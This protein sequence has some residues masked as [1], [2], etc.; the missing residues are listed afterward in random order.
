MRYRKLANTDVTLSEVGFGVW[1]VSAGWW[2]EFSDDQAADLL[3]RALDLGVTF[4]DTGDTYGNGR[5]ETILAKAFKGKRDQIVIGTKFGYDF[6]SNPDLNRGQRERPHDWSPGFVRFALEQSLKRLETDYVDLW[7]LHN[8]RMD[9]I[10]K[11]DLFALLEQ[12]KA[13]GKIRAYGA[14]LG[15]AIGGT[16]HGDQALQARK[17]DALQI[18]FN[19][20]EQDPGRRFL[21]LARERSV[22]I[23]VRV[24]HS[25]GMLEGKYTP[26]TTFPPSDHRSHRPRSWLIEGLQKIETLRFL[27][28][29]RGMTL[30]QAA[31]KWVLAEP[32]I[33]SAQP[34][35][36]DLAQ[37]EEFAAAPDLP[38]LSQDDLQKVA[39]LYARNFDLQPSGV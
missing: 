18:I 30:G 28:E 4:F 19:L 22:G 33:T 2:G 15:P 14:S 13:E 10:L 16:E 6:Y 12:L 21:P 9:A 24:P 37:L 38:D 5:G 3:R 36:Y 39:A 31:L 11:D 1:T 20:L 8:P 29:G 26:E 35:I 17:L 27:Y 34:N 32:T 25:S 7:M 23:L